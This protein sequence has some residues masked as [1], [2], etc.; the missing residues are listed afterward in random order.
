MLNKVIK[1]FLENRIITAFLLIG[2]L[3]GGTGDS[4]LQLAWWVDTA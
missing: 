3:F 4:T 1:Y 2:I